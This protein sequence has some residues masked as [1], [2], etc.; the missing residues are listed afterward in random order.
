MSSAA[1]SSSGTAS[2]GTGSEVLD[3][4]AVVIGEEAAF[5][6]AWEFRGTR[7]YVPK[8]MAREPRI[9]MAI[10]D[11]LARQFC[12]TFWRTTIS[13]PLNVVLERRI[14]R[15]LADGATKREIARTCCIR[16][17]RVYSILAR[18][19]NQ[20]TGPKNQ[21]DRQLPLL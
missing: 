9:A 7:L 4:I 21:D 10:G 12:D 20:L 8:D 1:A 2:S 19:K 6:L 5:A 13:L 18:A 15:M 11:D 16:E 14:A 17:A 3:D